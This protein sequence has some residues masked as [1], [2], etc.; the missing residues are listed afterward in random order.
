MGLTFCKFESEFTYCLWGVFSTTK[1]RVVYIGSFSF[2]CILMLAC[3]LRLVEGV[4]EQ[5]LVIYATELV[6]T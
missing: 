6:A 2:L 3:R 4:R 1:E 5:T